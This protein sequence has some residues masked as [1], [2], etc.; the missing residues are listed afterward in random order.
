VFLDLGREPVV[1]KSNKEIASSLGIS[2]STVKAHVTSLMN[3]PGV[4]D[5][6]EAAT[7]AVRRGIVRLH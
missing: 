7:Q 1:G 5:R 2:D 6:T 4:S 3:K